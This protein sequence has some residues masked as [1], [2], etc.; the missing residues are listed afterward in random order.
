MAIE[1]L[2]SEENKKLRRVIDE[3]IASNTRIADERAAIKDLINT[4]AED[5][6]LN[7]KAIRA[8]IKAA[9]K[10]DMDAQKEL[11]EET[12]TILELVGRR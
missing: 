9:T 8:A 4:V 7:A 5:L 2:S 11:N 3:G 12:E 1:N 6:G 10:D